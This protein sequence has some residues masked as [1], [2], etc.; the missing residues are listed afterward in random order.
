MNNKISKFSAFLLLDSLKEKYL[1]LK[2]SSK[3]A[4]Y[5][6]VIFIIATIVINFTYDSINKTYM[7][8]KIK[9][10]SFEALESAES[11]TN[12]IIDN[13]SNASK[14]IV[15]SDDIQSNLKNANS[16]TDLELQN[17]INKYLTQFTNFN[18]NIAS[19]YILDNYSN[20]YYSENN[21]YKNFNVDE[22]KNMDWYNELIKKNGGYILK[23]NGG[24][25]F[26]NKE[27]DYE[28]YVSFIR[29]INDINTQEKIGVLIININENAFYD[30]IVKV[31]NKSGTKLIIEDENNKIITKPD[32]EKGI[33]Q[34]AEKEKTY[35]ENKGFIIKKIDKKDYI[36]SSIK[37]KNNNWNLISIS[38]YSQLGEQSKYIRYFILIFIVVNII[39]IILGAFGISRMITRPLTKL[40]QSMRAVK[41]G[42]FKAVD[43][44]TYN[45]E[46][47]EVKNV[48]NIMVSHI[49]FLLNKIREDEKFKRKA[50]LDVLM[51]QIK[52]HFLYNTFDTISSLALSGE[53]R[54]VYEIIKALGA[55][56][57]T[58]L[59]NG[60]DIITVEEE[61][62]TI[63]SYLLI[64]NVRYRD[65]FEVQYDLSQ[66][67]D[68]FKIIKLVLQPLVENAIYHGLRNKTVKGFIKISVYE[69][70]NSV[71]LEVEDN[72]E[73]IDED[74][75]KSINEGK[76]SG[77]GVR[78]TKERLR[79][80]Y[81][82]ECKF[83]VTSEKGR[84]TKIA[85]KIPKKD[86]Y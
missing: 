12:I 77:I 60:R 85:I 36:I 21:T 25:L 18:P 10:S 13:V 61:I 47:G 52:P 70:E 58:S 56:Y 24:G 20:K 51:S 64:Q 67:C 15:S 43:I 57:R 71:V 37:M 46:V 27:Y 31:S 34:E 82:E 41:N 33:L 9:Q 83:S 26:H 62:K 49:K 17:N 55:F 3:I 35:T 84:G 68:G 29:I 19:I 4:I 8:E 16:Q 76:T 23:L 73:G 7:T 86:V 78:A 22:I 53:N 30:S 72:G 59:N 48:Y 66:N 44:K 42:E 6:S 40:H 38:E 5:F 79:V 2:I 63:K 80:F 14:M 54:S 32:I 50:E 28:S 81:G 39:L 65:K 1:N 69:E 11:S 75:L 45:D 74:K